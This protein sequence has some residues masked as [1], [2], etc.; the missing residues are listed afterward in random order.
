M[1]WHMDWITEKSESGTWKT[2]RK[3]IGNRTCDTMACGEYRKRYTTG[4]SL[5]FTYKAEGGRLVLPPVH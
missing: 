3:G 4:I 5:S 2:I 1:V